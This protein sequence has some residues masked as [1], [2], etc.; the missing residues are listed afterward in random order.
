MKYTDCPGFG[1]FFPSESLQSQVFLFLFL[2][3]LHTYNN[4]KTE[5]GQNSD[6]PRNEAIS[7][8]ETNTLVLSHM[9]N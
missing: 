3:I 6:C 2:F 4:I 5:R 1:G 9:T 8:S 7:N